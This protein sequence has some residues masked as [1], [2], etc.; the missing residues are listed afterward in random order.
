MKC[1]NTP[2]EWHWC[3]KNKDCWENKIERSVPIIF[4]PNPNSE[5]EYW[6][7]KTKRTKG[8]KLKKH[9]Q[10]V[11]TGQTIEE[12]LYEC[13]YCRTELTYKTLTIDHKTPLS[14]L[15][16]NHKSNLVGCCND[17]NREKGSSDYKYFLKHKNSILM[18]NYVVGISSIFDN[19][20]K[21]FKIEADNKYE[22]VKKSMVEY[23]TNEE[24]KQREIKYQNSEYYPKDFDSLCLK[25]KEILFNVIEI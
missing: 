18:K 1:N 13:H 6:P 19:D 8:K 15:G 22:A 5:T 16:S 2:C 7:Y 3:K 20:L 24:Y 23:W 9:I 17:C 14:K 11:Q 4:D 10:P 12:N 21:L 25:N